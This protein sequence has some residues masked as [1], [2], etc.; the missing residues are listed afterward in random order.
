[1]QAEKKP[2]AATKEAPK[3]EEPAP[4][5]PA[6]EAPAK[7]FSFFSAPVEPPAPAPALPPA[8]APA[9]KPVAPEPKK[10]EPVKPEPAKATKVEEKKP[11]PK[12]VEPVKDTKKRKSNGFKL[13]L[14][15]ML[16]AG[17]FVGFGYLVVT[18]GDELA[19][20]KTTVDDKLMQIGSK[21]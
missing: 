17:G 21:N 19:K 7:P 5:A 2:A 3:K 18:K 1:L 8:P 6:P 16:M 12:K 15:Q 9:P 14:S 10:A 20:V 13:F 4:P 11:E